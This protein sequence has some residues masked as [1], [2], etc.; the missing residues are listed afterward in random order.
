MAFH[1]LG[2]ACFYIQKHYLNFDHQNNFGV[3]AAEST[4]SVLTLLSFVVVLIHQFLIHLMQS[5]FQSVVCDLQ[6]TQDKRRWR[7]FR[8]GHFHDEGQKLSVLLQ[9]TKFIVTSSYQYDESWQYSNKCVKVIAY[10]KYGFLIFQ[11][12]SSRVL[13]FHV[14]WS[15]S[16]KAPLA[17][18]HPLP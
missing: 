5:H 7:M 17:R 10:V 3:K 2:A 16:I 12:V 8:Q 18:G 4:P 14:Q 6:T 15:P 11:K 1:Q 9:E 13:T